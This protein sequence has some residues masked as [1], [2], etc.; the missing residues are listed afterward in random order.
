LIVPQF[1][2]L[3][4][5]YRSTLEVTV[6]DHTETFWVHEIHDTNKLRVR[7]DQYLHPGGWVTSLVAFDEHKRYS[8]FN[9]SSC[10]VHNL[11]PTIKMHSIFDMLRDHMPQLVYQGHYDARGVRCDM[12]EGH[13]TYQEDG[14]TYSEDAIWFFAL[15]HFNV[16][17][18]PNLHR[19]PVQAILRTNNTRSHIVSFN[20]HVINFLEYQTVW[21]RGL[22][23]KSNCNPNGT[24]QA[25]RPCPRG[26]RTAREG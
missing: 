12:W 6:T 15:P 24:A 5:N 7:N 3:P 4:V 20:F 14:L 8:I 10:V 19:R 17:E 9:G 1:P 11:P 18:D 21:R 26:L 2:V 13:W 22:S 23:A 16:V 25:D